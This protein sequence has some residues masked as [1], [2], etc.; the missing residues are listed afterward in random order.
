VLK[1][2][3]RLKTRVYVVKVGTSGYGNLQTMSTDYCCGRVLVEL[4]HACLIQLV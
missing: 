2:D 3:G 1:S 4:V